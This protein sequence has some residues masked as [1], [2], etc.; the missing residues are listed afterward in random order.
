MHTAN[1]H[2]QRLNQLFR[3]TEEERQNP[4]RVVEEFFSFFD[5]Q[6]MHE[7]L[8]DW[9]VAAMSN[10]SGSFESGYSRSNLIFVYERLESL[11][12]ASYVIHMRRKKKRKWYYQKRNVSD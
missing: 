4:Y 12:E 7:I 1:R 3:L 5:T 9:L 2:P 8:W 11:I 6:D 10:E